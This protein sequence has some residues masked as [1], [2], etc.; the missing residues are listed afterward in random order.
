MCVIKNVIPIYF[1]VCIKII[2]KYRF[3]GFISE[4]EIPELRT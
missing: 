2:I 4:L 1:P 3:Q